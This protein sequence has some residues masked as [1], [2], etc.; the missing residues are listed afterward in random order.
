MALAPY[1]KIVTLHDEVWSKMYR[2]PVT[3][4]I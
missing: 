4:G 2:Y 3:N 1:G